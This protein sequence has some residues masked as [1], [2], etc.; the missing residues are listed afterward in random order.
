MFKKADIEDLIDVTRRNGDYHK[1]EGRT[2]IEH[3]HDRII[4]FVVSRKMTIHTD[5]MRVV[6]GRDGSLITAYPVLD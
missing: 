6:L 4:G 2:L 1:Q 5:K 3:K